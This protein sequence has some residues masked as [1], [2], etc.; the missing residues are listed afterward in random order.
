V[1][2]VSGRVAPAA[3]A[4]ASIVSTLL[5]TVV[6]VAVL[7]LDSGQL[8]PTE[9]AASACV[10]FGLALPAWLFA[11]LPLALFANERVRGTWRLPCIGTACGC[12]Y[13]GLWS[14]GLSPYAGCFPMVV[15]A[16]VGGTAG[17]FFVAL[18][19]LVLPTR[20]RRAGPKHGSG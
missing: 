8:A 18:H 20:V 12:A 13:G 17:V 1:R 15:G 3:R 19:I 9:A 14:L 5:A 6:W 16:L 7:A 4:F 2:R 10:L 11:F